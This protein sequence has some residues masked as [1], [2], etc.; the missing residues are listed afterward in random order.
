M[1]RSRLLPFETPLVIAAAARERKGGEEA[2][3]GRTDAGAGAGPFQTNHAARLQAGVE[4]SK[5]ASN[6]HGGNR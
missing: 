3:D 6:L 2:R 5:Q 1:N 4:T